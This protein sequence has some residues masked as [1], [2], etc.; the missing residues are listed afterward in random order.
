MLFFYYRL[1][2][3]TFM[4]A[5]AGGSILPTKNFQAMAYGTC[6]CSELA[7]IS[8]AVTALSPAAVIKDLKAS[9]LHVQATSY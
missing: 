6:A 8:V 7:A 2:I 3:L 5:T 4:M 1:I 9:F